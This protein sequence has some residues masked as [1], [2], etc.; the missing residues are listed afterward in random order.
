MTNF[1]A[2]RWPHPTFECGWDWPAPRGKATHGCGWRLP[3]PLLSE[4][5]P[6]PPPAPPAPAPAALPPFLPEALVP[7]EHH[8]TE[9]APVCQHSKATASAHTSCS[10]PS[11]TRCEHGTPGTLVRRCLPAAADTESLSTADGSSGS[12]Y[13]SSCSSSS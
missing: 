11:W 5:A 8:P 12:Q 10:K 2:S 3:P 4:G 6:F 7:A 13:S 9:N 1:V